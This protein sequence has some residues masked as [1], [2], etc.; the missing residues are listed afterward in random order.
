LAGAGIDTV[1]VAG[2]D[3]FSFGVTPGAITGSG[4]A[5]TVAV[6]T[7]GTATTGATLT[8][9]IA[10]ALTEAADAGFFMAITDSGTGNTF[11]GTYLAL[12]YDTTFSAND[13]LIR[14][15]GTNVSANDTLLINN[16]TL[17]YTV[18]A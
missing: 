16:A 6:G 5:T 7:A 10:A 2:A 4:A 9:A 11:T 13:I 3:I 8:A 14:L 17:V 12:T 18:V 1:S 15:I